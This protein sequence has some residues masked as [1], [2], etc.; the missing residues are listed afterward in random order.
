MAQV[1]AATKRYRDASWLQKEGWKRF[2]GD[3]RLMGEHWYRPTGPDYVS[4]Q[5]IDFARPSNLMYTDIAGKKVLVG[6]AFHAHSGR[7]FR[8][9]QPRAAV[10]ETRTSRR[11]RGRRGRGRR[12]RASSRDRER[13]RRHAGRRAVDNGGHAR[14]L[15]EACGDAAMRRRRSGPGSARAT[16]RASTHSPRSSGRNGKPHGI[17][18][19]RRSSVRASRP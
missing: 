9:L 4:G 19:S 13:L 15:R 3:E 1:A 17:G 2:G 18:S 6:V 12:A 7:R 16:P 10:S 14:A 5:P 11:V 8:G